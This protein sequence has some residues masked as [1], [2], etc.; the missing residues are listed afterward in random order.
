MLPLGGSTIILH[1]RK[2]L[3]SLEMHLVHLSQSIEMTFDTQTPKTL[4]QGTAVAN[5]ISFTLK[6]TARTRIPCLSSLCGS[7]Y[8]GDMMG[9]QCHSNVTLSGNIFPHFLIEKLC[10]VPDSFCFPYLEQKGHMYTRDFKKLFSNHSFFPR[11]I[12][13]RS[14]LAENS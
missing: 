9:F 2:L 12:A 10:S 11:T 7:D 1:N 5:L 13:V 8:K 4:S 14:S 3:S 6:S